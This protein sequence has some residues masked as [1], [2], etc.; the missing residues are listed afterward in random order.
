M[1]SKY[2]RDHI[3]SK[4]LAPGN[5][6]P[7]EQE[8]MEALNVSRISVRKAIEELREQGDVYCVQGSGTFVSEKPRQNTIQYIPLVLPSE[9]ANSE[10][11]EVVRGVD[12]CLNANSCFPTLHFSHRNSVE[13]LEILRRLVEHGSR[14]I[15]IFPLNSSENHVEYMKMVR[16][17]VRLVFLDRLPWSVT[18]SQVTCDNLNG[19]YIATNHLLSKGYRRICFFSITKISEA[20]TLPQRV[21]GYRVALEEHG[22]PFDELLL[23][24]ADTG[25]TTEARVKR[26]LG[27]ANPPDAF[28]CANDLAA[29]DVMQVLSGLNVAVPDQV[30]LVG[31]DN[32]PLLQNYPFSI[33]T[34]EQS[35]FNMGYE[36][37]EIAC[38]IVNNQLGYSVHKILPVS[39][40]ERE[41]TC[42]SKKTK[43]NI[44]V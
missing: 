9:S 12:K 21:E 1:V 18:A 26:L 41:S 2:L 19:G 37:A 34:I 42:R 38:R 13:E 23:S 8:L 14:C 32:M 6:L 39:L 35:F 33:T 15:I 22:L 7:T 11:F 3:D 30:G 17:G 24:F 40:V 27:G 43:T 20:T 31:F 36:A 25:E 29:I 5:K 10:L 16:N 4:K 44:R 28:F